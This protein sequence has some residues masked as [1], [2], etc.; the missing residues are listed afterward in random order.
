MKLVKQLLSVLLAMLLA[1]G[2]FLP[3]AYAEEGEVIAQE[4][5]TEEV[6]VQE[7]AAQDVIVEEAPVITITK[8]PKAFTKTLT[9][10]EVTLSVEAKM[11]ESV[12]STLRYQ[13]YYLNKAGT[14]VKME[15]ETSPALRLRLML[16]SPDEPL[17]NRYYFVTITCDYIED[18]QEK[19]VSAASE[20]AEV[21]VYPSPTDC[22]RTIWSFVTTVIHIKAEGSAAKFA[23]WIVLVFELPTMLL[24][25]LASPIMILFNYI[26]FWT[27]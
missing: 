12:D 15:G 21:A 5:A 22:F 19:S 26:R 18:G 23:K 8:Q 2:L 25:F 27:A 3:A 4:V 14:A 10:K 7:V 13:W 1:F 24:M 17:V 11:P 6:D 16:D 20:K 9:N